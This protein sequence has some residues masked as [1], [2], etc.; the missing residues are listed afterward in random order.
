MC[1]L[2]H[3][4]VLT[5]AFLRALE[6]RV[7]MKTRDMCFVFLF[8]IYPVTIVSEDDPRFFRNSFRI[9]QLYTFHTWELPSTT[10]V[11]YSFCL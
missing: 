10:T 5:K 9:T 4:L 3:M 8:L 2:T 6:M 1:Q 11:L 7:S